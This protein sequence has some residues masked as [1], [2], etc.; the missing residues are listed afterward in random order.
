[1]SIER[2]TQSTQ[3]L[4]ATRIINKWQFHRFIRSKRVV[5]FTFPAEVKGSSGDQA[6]SNC[7]QPGPWSAAPPGAPLCQPDTLTLHTA[8]SA[9]TKLALDRPEAKNLY[10]GCSNRSLAHPL[11]EA[12]AANKRGTARAA[13]YQG[14]RQLSPPFRASRQVG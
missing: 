3:S 1:M 11:A 6:L 9:T 2:S 14:E 12:V 5:K 7:P 8:V 13:V 10:Y 4:T